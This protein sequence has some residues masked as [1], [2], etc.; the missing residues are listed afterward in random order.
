MLLKGDGGR[1]SL[2][3]KTWISATF[4]GLESREDPDA[5]LW[6]STES[7]AYAFATLSVMCNHFCGRSGQLHT[8]R[9]GHQCQFLVHSVFLKCPKTAG[10]ELQLGIPDCLSTRGG[11]SNER[12]WD[13]WRRYP[14]EWVGKTSG[15]VATHRAAAEYRFG[16]FLCDSVAGRS[17]VKGS[18]ET[19]DCAK[20]CF[21][22]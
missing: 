4:G 7:V 6:R 13:M 20:V 1:V 22:S 21:V 14:E 16:V 15:M 9:V 3:L 11:W 12:T 2:K 8:L 5:L 18:D 17:M 19:D 10:G